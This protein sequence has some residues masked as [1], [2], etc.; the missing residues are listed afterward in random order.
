MHENAER[1]G[2][3]RRT[4]LPRKGDVLIWA[5]DLAHGGSAV[6]D[7][8]LTRRSLVGHYCPSRAEPVY[9]KLDPARRA[10]VQLDSGGFA[11]QHYPLAGG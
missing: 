8:A 3:E 7:P 2:L 1:M 9:F 6:T 5:A 10:Q 11:S 4:F